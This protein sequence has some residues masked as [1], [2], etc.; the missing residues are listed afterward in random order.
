MSEDDAKTRV[1]VPGTKEKKLGASVAAEALKKVA[2]AGYPVFEPRFCRATGV[3]AIAREVVRELGELTGLEYSLKGIDK[4]F[5][6]ILTKLPVIKHVV[7]PDDFHDEELPMEGYVV[8]VGVDP[9][10]YTE[11]REKAPVIAVTAREELDLDKTPLVLARNDL[12]VDKGECAVLAL[13]AADVPPER[14]PYDIEVLTHHDLYGQM[15][16]L[17]RFIA[18][19]VATRCGYLKFPYVTVKESLLLDSGEYKVR[20]K[21]KDRPG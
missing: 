16:K 20:I 6:K 4:V 17:A 19:T 8:F 21:E 5:D 7:A 13:H 18:S 1:W 14:P 12:C 2:E 3:K 11:V 10:E 9:R 15:V